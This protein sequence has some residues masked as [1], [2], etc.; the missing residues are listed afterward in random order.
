[1]V[2]DIPKRSRDQASQKKSFNYSD[3]FLHKE[4]AFPMI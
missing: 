3:I 4:F 1:M 2:T